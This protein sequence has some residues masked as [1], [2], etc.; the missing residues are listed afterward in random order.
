MKGENA[1]TFSHTKVSAPTE[2]VKK[3]KSILVKKSD[4][5][6]HIEFQSV[7][8]VGF[9]YIFSPGLE[10]FGVLEKIEIV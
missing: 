3:S 7:L 8:C 1:A 2:T 4:I 5:F 6:A 10:P 9:D